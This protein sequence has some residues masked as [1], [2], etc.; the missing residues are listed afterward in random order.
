MMTPTML[1]RITPMRL[2]GPACISEVDGSGVTDG[3]GVRVKGMM[4]SKVDVCKE[5]EVEDTLEF[6]ALEE[7][8]DDL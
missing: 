5:I 3:A 7:R 8:V 2:S 4:E 6:E 1:P